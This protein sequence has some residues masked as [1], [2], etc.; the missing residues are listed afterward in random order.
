MQKRNLPVAEPKEN[1]TNPEYANKNDHNTIMQSQQKPL[2]SIDCP[3]QNDILFGRGWNVSDCLMFSIIIISL[4][5]QRLC[6]VIYIRILPDPHFVQRNTFFLFFFF[7]LLL[8]VADDD[9]T[10]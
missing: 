8:F 6:Y 10:S 2:L 5:L 7:P 9:E 3:R 4:S 1:K